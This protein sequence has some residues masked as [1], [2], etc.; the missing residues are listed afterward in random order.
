MRY[1]RHHYESDCARRSLRRMVGAILG[2]LGLALMLCRFRWWRRT[3]AESGFE[4]GTTGW[5]VGEGQLHILD[6]L[7]RRA[8]VCVGSKPTP[9]GMAW[10]N[11]SWVCWQPTNTY[12]ISAGCDWSAAAASLSVTI[13]KTDGGG[14][15]TL[16]WP[17]ARPVPPNWTLLSGGYTLAVNETLTNLTLYIEGPAGVSFY[18]DDFV[19]ETLRLEGTGDARIGQ[20]RNATCACC[21][22]R[23]GNPCPEL[24]ST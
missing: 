1:V 11:R 9:P 12:R 17:I 20:I 22:R 3:G 18:T 16:P 8:A 6:P 4:F 13:Q 7:P 15:P 23:R 21:C 14:R 2:Q 24:L 19:V 10:R 5:S